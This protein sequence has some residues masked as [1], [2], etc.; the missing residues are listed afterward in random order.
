MLN[1]FTGDEAHQIRTVLQ[2]ILMSSDSIHN[3][4]STTEKSVHGSIKLNI[5]YYKYVISK[6]PKSYK[7]IKI[8][9]TNEVNNIIRGCSAS[10]ILLYI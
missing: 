6:L 7:Y 1:L 10:I 8:Y 3:F 2:K 4:E 5:K 9:I